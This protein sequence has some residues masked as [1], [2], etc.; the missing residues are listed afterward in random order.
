MDTLNGRSVWK[1][2]RTWK[3]STDIKNKKGIPFEDVNC[4]EL[5][6]YEVQESGVL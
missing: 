3:N 1:L 4:I 5:D 2:R 6:R